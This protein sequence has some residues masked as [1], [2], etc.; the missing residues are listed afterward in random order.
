MRYERPGINR[1]PD[2]GGGRG[3]GATSG[4]EI[5]RSL[6]Q[7]VRAGYTHALTLVSQEI[8]GRATAATRE[9]KSRVIHATSPGLAISPAYPAGRYNTILNAFAISAAATVVQG[10]GLTQQE[11]QTLL[12]VL[13]ATEGPQRDPI[14]AQ[15]KAAAARWSTLLTNPDIRALFINDPHGQARFFQQDQSLHV[16]SVG[17]GHPAGSG[18][19][20]YDSIEESRYCS[21]SDTPFLAMEKLGKV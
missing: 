6:E 14:A 1:G 10:E 8:R 15:K 17:I 11:T 7:I 20:H 2:F 13:S 18:G 16:V 12:E 5:P 19:I 4:S 9:A 21:S 3:W